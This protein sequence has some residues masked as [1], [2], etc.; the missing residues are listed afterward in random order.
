MKRTSIFLICTFFSASAFTQ[1]FQV[2]KKQFNGTLIYGQLS[3]DEVF[4]NDGEKKPV[5]SVR[6]QELNLQMCYGLLENTEVY[7]TAPFISNSTETAEGN[8]NIQHAGDL[9][10]GIRWRYPMSDKHWLGIDLQQSLA[11]GKR[12]PQIFL[13][14][15]YVDNHTGLWLFYQSGFSSKYWL[16]ADA[17]YV[18]HYNTFCDE[19]RASITGRLHV[20]SPLY[21]ELKLEGRRPFENDEVVLNRYDLGLFQDNSGCIAGGIALRVM[22]DNKPG[23][24]MG[25]STPI[26]GQFIPAAAQWYAGVI[27]HL[28]KKQE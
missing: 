9:T 16:Q 28:S 17:G 26:R 3:F 2:Q 12:D 11:T 23:L 21:L 1:S 6:H 8:K 25:L 18:F 24:V 4:D 15:G 13:H 5:K 19:F 14:T 7:F 27:W 22:K 20:Y 10:A